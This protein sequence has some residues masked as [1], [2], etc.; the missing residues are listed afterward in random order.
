MINTLKTLTVALFVPF[1]FIFTSCSM[2]KPQ[3]SDM[4]VSPEAKAL[5]KEIHDFNSL[6]NPCKGTGQ[7]YITTNDR[8]VSYSIAY[9]SDGIK[10]VRLEFLT[11]VGLPA[12][13]VATDGKK[14]YFAEGSEQDIKKYSNPDRVF[15]KI[16]GL[17]VKSEFISM[18]ICGKIPLINFH[19][20]SIS[21]NHGVKTLIL[22]KG[23]LTQTIVKTGTGFGKIIEFKKDDSPLY[24]FLTN[25]T[26]NFLIHSGNPFVKISFNRDIYVPVK[27]HN[28]NDI[29]ILTR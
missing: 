29:F 25:D 2:T 8:N 26:G 28:S 14:I 12:A 27:N 7:V 19:K 17:P 3:I 21:Q 18:L 5:L 15:K 6:K 9:A 10:K 20:Y 16:L 1:I 11:P 4:V 13:K 24:T 22:E 23:N